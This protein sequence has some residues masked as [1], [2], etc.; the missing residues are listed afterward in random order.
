MRVGFVGRCSLVLLSRF[1]PWREI[2]A[3]VK[4]ATV[5]RWHRQGFKVFWR[6][7]CRKG[8]RPPVPDELRE[9]I[10]RMAAENPTWSSDRIADE[11]R[12]KLGLRVSPRTVR[13]Y[14]PDVPGGRGHRG[15]GDQRWTTFVKNHA[16]A[17][18]ACDFFTT[19]TAS[20]RVLY[21]FVAMEVGSRRI[22]HCNVT[23][24]PTAEWTTRQLRQGIPHDHRWR[25]LIHD[26][27]S[28]FS[29]NLDQTVARMGLRVLKNPVR[30]PRA[31]AF[32]ERLIGTIRR[33]CLDWLIPL[34]EN[35][36]R[37]ILLRWA[38]H[39][40]EAR[41]HSSLGPGI[42]NPPPGLPLPLQAHRHCLPDG[43]RVAATPILGGL[44]H[45]YRLDRAA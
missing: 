21:V 40:N 23:A 17:I 8:G 31:N 3:V 2:I 43:A 16:E 35:H 10:R 12:L 6:R 27:D 18:V 15:R 22:L 33:E 20:F 34:S 32:C 1:C 14:V 38:H 30:A 24:N 45:E 36:L 42:P 25:F 13:K 7:K 19:V 9:I 41:P 4:P 28:I 29:T 11:L 44:H 26:R 37:C 39:Y 5:I